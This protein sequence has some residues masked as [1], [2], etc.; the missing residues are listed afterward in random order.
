V[1]NSIT[2]G[3]VYNHAFLYSGGAMQDLGTLPGATTS[4]GYGINSGGRIVGSSGNAFLFNDGV[5]ED[6]NTLVATNSGWWLLTASDINDK[7]QIV[8]WGIDPS[9]NSQAFLL[10]PI[11]EPQLGA[12]WHWEA[13]SFSEHSGCARK[14]PH[15]P[16]LIISAGCDLRL[17]K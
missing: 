7:D 14:R 3:G 10:D 13:A 5:M 8:G 17:P 6:L 11:P 15:A 12:W 2:K 16:Q 9:G 1:G 4:Y